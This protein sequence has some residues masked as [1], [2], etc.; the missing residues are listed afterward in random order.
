M[1]SDYHLPIFVSQVVGCIGPQARYAPDNLVLV[2]A[3]AADCLSE[4]LGTMAV[5]EA[6]PVGFLV[7]GLEAPYLL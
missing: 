6:D 5:K 4:L 1:L 3:S 7:M 2:M